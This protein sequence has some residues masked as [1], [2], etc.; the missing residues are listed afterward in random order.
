MN[1]KNNKNN[2][3]KNN[4]NNKNNKNKMNHLIRFHK[5]DKQHLIWVIHNNM[6]AILNWFDIQ[7][8]HKFILVN[9]RL[10]KYLGP[11]SKKMKSKSNKIR[12]DML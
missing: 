1:N 8:I 5:Q 4:K 12:M 10:P 3:K 11:I 2:N 6:N 9:Q 7:W